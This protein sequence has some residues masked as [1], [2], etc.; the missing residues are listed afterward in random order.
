MGRGQSCTRA[1]CSDSGA[2]GKSHSLGI[3]PSSLKKEA[4]GAAKGQ[5][6]RLGEPRTNTLSARNSRASV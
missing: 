4:V 5:V 2:C 1:E 3:K 6:G